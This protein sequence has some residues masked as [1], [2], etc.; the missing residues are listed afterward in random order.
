MKQLIALLLAAVMLLGMASCGNAP[1]AV[2]PDRAWTHYDSAVTL[3][4]NEKYDQAIE[5]LKLS[6]RYDNTLVYTYTLLAASY[7]MLGEYQ[8][9]LDVLDGAPGQVKQDVEIKNMREMIRQHLQYSPGP[10]RP[11]TTQPETTAPETEEYSVTVRDQERLNELPLEDYRDRI[12]AVKCRDLDETADLTPLTLL[13][14]LR[15]LDLSDSQD[16]TDAQLK[17]LSKCK[18]LEYPKPWLHP[19]HHRQ[20]AGRS[21]R[22]QGAGSGQL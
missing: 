16:L 8:A 9:A 6:L 13:P 11:E 3:Y 1:A 19:S 4:Q 14:N 7:D 5:E 20:Y 22:P 17:V 15:I 10:S 21:P 2:D 18:A 12:V